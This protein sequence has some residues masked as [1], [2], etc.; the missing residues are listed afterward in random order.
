MTGTLTSKNAQANLSI[1]KM[2]AAMQY[3]NK[4]NYHSQVKEQD[5]FN[6]SKTE[7]KTNRN[8]PQN[9][10]RAFK[11]YQSNFN[12]GITWNNVFRFASNNSETGSQ[13]AP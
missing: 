8:G 2:F 6:Y 3:S 7:M 10:F 11:N 12:Q 9:M 5:S 13:N 4:F 1:N